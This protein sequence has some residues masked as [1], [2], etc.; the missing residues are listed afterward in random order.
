MNDAAHLSSIR[1]QLAAI[2]G[3][4]VLASGR[5][6]D[7]GD[8]VFIEATGP[9]GELSEVATFH[10]DASTEE[11]QFAASAPQHVRFLLGLIDRAITKARGGKPQPP[12][13]EKQRKDYA[14]EAAMKCAAP[15]FKKFLMENHGLESPASDERTAQKLRSLLGVTSRAELNHDDQAALRWKALRGDFENWRRAG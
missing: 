12:E 15:A 2:D 7:G 10:P 6:A 11:M 8:R 14:A 5:Q 1:E 4:W 9:M 13:P 3:E